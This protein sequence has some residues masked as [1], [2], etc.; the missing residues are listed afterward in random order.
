[1]ILSPAQVGDLDLLCYTIKS[2]NLLGPLR[3]LLINKAV[4]IDYYARLQEEEAKDRRLQ[5]AFFT[6]KS[7]ANEQQIIDAG[8]EFSATKLE[9]RVAGGK[10]AAKK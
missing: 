3:L 9:V 8:G 5:Q 4:E 6:S 10:Q 2:Q 7:V 1:M